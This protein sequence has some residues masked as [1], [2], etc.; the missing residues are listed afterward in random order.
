M[1]AI[2][3]TFIHEAEVQRQH[4]RH[5]LPI[6]VILH[7]TVFSVTDWSLGGISI[8]LNGVDWDMEFGDDPQVGELVPLQLLF[9]FAGFNFSLACQR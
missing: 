5:R 6:K 2:E 1:G 7:D 9:E 4:A 8:D 3:S